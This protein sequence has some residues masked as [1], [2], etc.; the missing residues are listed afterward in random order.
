[1]PQ[2][3]NSAIQRGVLFLNVLTP[4]PAFA[5]VKIALLP[6]YTLRGGANASKARNGEESRSAK[7]REAGQE[8]GYD[9]KDR[10]SREK[11]RC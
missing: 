6:S 4:L 9:K 10:Q 1:M 8:G 7:G 5:T 11:D 3:Q 2:L